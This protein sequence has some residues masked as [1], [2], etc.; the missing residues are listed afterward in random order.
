[1]RLTFVS[2]SLAVG[3]CLDDGVWTTSDISDDREAYAVGVR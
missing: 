2:W 1:M 3:S